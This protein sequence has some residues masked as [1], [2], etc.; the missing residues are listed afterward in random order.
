MFACFFAEQKPHTTKVWQNYLEVTVNYFWENSI[1]KRFN[2]LS[3]LSLATKFTFDLH[4]VWSIVALGVFFWGKYTVFRICTTFSG[5]K[6]VAGG[7]KIWSQNQ[8][9]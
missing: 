6:M 1:M 4:I 2:T 3:R 9:Q 5:Q 7:L 8:Q